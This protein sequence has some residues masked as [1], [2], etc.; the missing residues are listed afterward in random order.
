[1]LAK[2]KLNKLFNMSLKYILKMSK[3]VIIDEFQ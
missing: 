1:M 2:K 3:L